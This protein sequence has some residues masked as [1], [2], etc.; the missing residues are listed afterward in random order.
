[1]RV[2]PKSLWA[3][4]AMTTV[5]GTYES[6]TI[7]TVRLTGEASILVVT[8]AGSLALTYQVSDDGTN[9][10]SPEDTSGSALNVINGAVIVGSNWIVFSPTLARYTRIVAVLTGADSTVSI[11]FRHSEEIL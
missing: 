1:M 6:A 7:D 5:T 8:S 4:E 10:Y 3:S 9:W 11:D 2:V